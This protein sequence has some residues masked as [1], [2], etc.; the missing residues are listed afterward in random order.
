MEERHNAAIVIE[1]IR[2]VAEFLREACPDREGR[3]SRRHGGRHFLGH[4]ITP[5]GYAKQGMTMNSTIKKSHLITYEELLKWL[6]VSRQHI[7]RLVNVGKFP[8]KIHVGR[9]VRFDSRDV[10]AWLESQRLGKPY[11]NNTKHKMQNA[12]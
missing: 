3:R 10:D 4:P 12:K 1:A 2:Q 11:Q 7:D 8:P 5:Q 6:G 9:R